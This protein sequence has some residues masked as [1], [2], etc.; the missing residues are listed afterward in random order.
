MNFS[1]YAMALCYT[2][3]SDFLKKEVPVASLCPS[4]GIA[5]CRCGVDCNLC[6][7][8]ICYLLPNSVEHVFSTHGATKFMAIVLTLHYYLL[9]TILM[10][11]KFSLMYWETEAAFCV[12]HVSAKYGLGRLKAVQVCQKI[13]NSGCG[14]QRTN[15]AQY[16]HYCKDIFGTSFLSSIELPGASPTIFPKLGRN[17][18]TLT[19]VRPRGS[20]L[21]L[22]GGHV[23]VEIFLP[24]GSGHMSAWIEDRAPYISPACNVKWGKRHTDYSDTSNAPIFQMSRIT[25]YSCCN[26]M[27]HY[28]PISQLYHA[29][30]RFV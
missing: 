30:C 3:F 1:T 9:E 28:K 14:H 12:L 4:G 24:P 17:W 6:C 8:C 23:V 5:L 29:R 20:V 19:G 10:K 13:I 21:T 15:V 22:P 7:R 16:G 18:R 26:Q 25:F 27:H 2:Y 11:L